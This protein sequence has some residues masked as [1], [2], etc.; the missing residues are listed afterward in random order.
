MKAKIEIS[1]VP[2]STI[3]EKWMYKITWSPAGI[4][5]CSG[6]ALNEEEAIAFGKRRAK[7][8]YEAHKAAGPTK[9][10]TL[11]FE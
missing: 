10:I 5:P 4:A 2:D 11:E 6:W 1:Y 9:T 7:K 3:A 8:E